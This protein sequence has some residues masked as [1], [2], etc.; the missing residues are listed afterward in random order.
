LVEIMKFGCP[1]FRAAF[2]AARWFAT[3][4]DKQ[5]RRGSFSSTRQLET[6]IR[7]YVD[8]HNAQPKPFIWTKSADDILDSI[9]RYCRRIND[10]GH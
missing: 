8:H 10:S 2:S 3:L 6:A 1:R 9:A 7:T 4:T 5:I